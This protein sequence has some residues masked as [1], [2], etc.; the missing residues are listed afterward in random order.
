VSNRLRQGTG[1]LDLP[2]VLLPPERGE[3]PRRV[4]I[5]I[6]IELVPTVTAKPHPRLWPWPF[7]PILALLL[8]AGAH[9]QDQSIHYDHWSDTNGWHGETM[10]QGDRIE[11]RDYGPHGERH[12]CRSYMVGT[13]RYTSCT[14]N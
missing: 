6:I 14:G 10:T 8:A 1:R 4:R 5:H 9:A 12:T 2:P 3:G 7:W 11:T 13:Q